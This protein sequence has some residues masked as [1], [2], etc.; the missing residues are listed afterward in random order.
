MARLPATS[1]WNSPRRQDV[2]CSIA[3]IGQ[4]SRTQAGGSETSVVECFAWNPPRHERGG[5]GKEGGAGG[6]EEE[7]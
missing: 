5:E 1:G 2:N 4:R 3:T 6:E 7:G